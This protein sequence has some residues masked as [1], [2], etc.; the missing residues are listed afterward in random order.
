MLTY[1]AALPLRDNLREGHASAWRAIAAPGAFWTAAERVAMVAEARAATACPLCAERKTA[2]SPFA[3]TG[4]HT[5]AALAGADLPATVVDMIH[6]IRTDPG[7]LTRSWF[8]ATLAAGIS[9]ARYVEA[10][11]VVCTSVIIDTLHKALDLELPDLP[12]PTPGAPTGEQN[13]RAVNAGAWVPISDGEGTSTADPSET[14]LPA[15]PNIA[16]AMGL[17]PGA[18]ALFFGAFRPHYALKD[19]PLAISQAQ[20]EFVASRVSAINECFY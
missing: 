7:R 15:V 16:R 6:R 9:P 1:P 3:V 13:P 5:R 20:A 14:G 4:T 18:V 2:L 10:V 17:V 8:D 11:S 12:A 19:I